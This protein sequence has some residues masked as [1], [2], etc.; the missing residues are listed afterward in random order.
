MQ[1]N[2]GERN[3]DTNPKKKHKR[4]S[5]K[6]KLSQLKQFKKKENYTYNGIKG[7]RYPLQ[8]KIV[9]HIRNF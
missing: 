6:E 2:E 7:K 8:Q 4:V 9:K 5:H 3:Y 1:K